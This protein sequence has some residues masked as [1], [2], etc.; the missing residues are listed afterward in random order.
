MIEEK[1]FEELVKQYQKMI[2]YHIKHL[3]ITK[4]QEEYHQIGLIALWN[5]SKTY[6][7]SKGTFSTYLY[8]CIRGQLLNEMNKQIRRQDHEQLREHHN[9][10]MMDN[11][12]IKE[13]LNE[14][15]VRSYSHILSPMQQ[16]WLIGYCIERKTPSEIA[17]SEKVSAASVKSWRREALKKIKALSEESYV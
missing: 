8:K 13:M 6:D 12:P 3:N 15:I 7:N 17:E 10:V 9:D 2:Y 4:N 14:Q 16:K 1:R 11:D 5:A